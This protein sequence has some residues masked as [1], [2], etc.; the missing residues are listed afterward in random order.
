MWPCIAISGSSY[1]ASVLSFW[2]R[3]LSPRIDIVIQDEIGKEITSPRM[4]RYMGKKSIPAMSQEV[5]SRLYYPRMNIEEPNEECFQIRI[6]EPSLEGVPL[7]SSQKLLEL[8]QK[9]G[10]V[11]LPACIHTAQLALYGNEIGLDLKISGS[12]KEEASMEF[13]DQVNLVLNEKKLIT[14]EPVSVGQEDICKPGHVI[15]EAPYGW[16]TEAKIYPYFDENIT[17]WAIYFSLLVVNVRESISKPE[18]LWIIEDPGERIFFY[19]GSPRAESSVKVSLTRD[20]YC[21]L[22]LSK[23]TK[24]IVGIFCSIDARETFLL[25]DIFSSFIEKSEP[26]KMMPEIAVTESELFK[27]SKLLRALVASWFKLCWG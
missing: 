24:R 27:E 14:D 5:F 8:I 26:C 1:F 18:S 15:F 25:G 2:L 10:R 17:Q 16:K 22:L 6:K 12:L 4:L 23:R 9:S 21:R 3:N 13:L 11:V 19:K 20:S 7:S